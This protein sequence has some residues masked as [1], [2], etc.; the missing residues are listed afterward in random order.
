MTN[1]TNEQICSNVRSDMQSQGKNALGFCTPRAT[2]TTAI[3]MR[4]YAVLT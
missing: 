2:G 4:H 1:V 3:T